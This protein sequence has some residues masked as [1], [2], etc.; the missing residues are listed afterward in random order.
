MSE[1]FYLGA[2]WGPRPESARA[3]ADRLVFCLQTLTAHGQNFGQWYLRGYTKAEASKHPVALDPNAI[4]TVLKRG[5][6]RRSSGGHPIITELGYS[7]GLWNGDLRQS[8]GLSVLCGCWS[9][10]VDNAFVLNLPETFARSASLTGFDAGR[11]LVEAAVES[12]DPDYA[13]L[14]TDNI[15]S[16]QATELGQPILG[17]ITYL[18]A[19]GQ[20]LPPLPAPAKVESLSNGGLLVALAPTYDE[21]APAL[22]RD[23]AALLL[24]AGLL[25]RPSQPR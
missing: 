3:C 5:Q 8:V 11:S 16:V 4:E 17:W 18:P 10:A 20:R 25:H 1:H 9:A 21:V 12:W 19:R 2:Y 23:V 22:V 14:G 24:Q 6:N 7:T 15:R 13:V